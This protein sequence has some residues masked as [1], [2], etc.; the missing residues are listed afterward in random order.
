MIF[1]SFFIGASQK[2]PQFE[3]TTHLK[4]G[5]LSWKLT[6]PILREISVPTNWSVYKFFSV[7]QKVIE[8]DVMVYNMTKNPKIYKN[9][10]LAASL[11]N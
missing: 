9:I 4:D 2:F 1:Y 7:T 5:L 3:K 11:E 8:I 10:F 6:I